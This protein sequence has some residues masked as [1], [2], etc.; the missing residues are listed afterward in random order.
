M[1]VSR[2]F[3]LSLRGYAVLVYAFLFLPIGVLALMS[4][5]SAQ[6]G[7]FPLSGLTGKW[8]VQ[9]AHDGSMWASLRYSLTVAAGTVATAVPLGVM[10]AYGLVR[11]RFVGQSLFS[12]I[13]VVPLIVPAMLIGI[14]MLSFFHY[15]GIQT[16]LFT[17]YLG[18]TALA[19]PYTSLIVAARLQGLDPHLEEAAAGL[20]APRWRVFRRVTLPLL[21]PGILG[22]ALFAFTISFGEIIVTFFVS[23]FRET[24]PLHIWSLLKLG[25]TP[26]TN[27]MSA[28][29]MFVGI[30][31][32]AAGLRLIAHREP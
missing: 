19:L 15:V 24:L 4:F 20:G 14:S 22:A 26:A 5:N 32:V 28:I 10:A 11:Y 12:A 31:V 25:I 3:S 1:S 8:Y 18:H 30:L 23:G 27:G 13:I 16:S 2:W 29:I 7:V 21:G 9:L 6:Y 17:V